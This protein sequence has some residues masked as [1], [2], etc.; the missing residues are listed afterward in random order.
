[1]AAALAAISF[2]SAV[3]YESERNEF[4]DAFVNALGGPTGIATALGA[5]MMA[6]AAKAINPDKDEKSG[7]D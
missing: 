1:M 4:R 2:G 6:G 5:L 3:L 7:P